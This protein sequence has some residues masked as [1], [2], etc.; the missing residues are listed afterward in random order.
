MP[1][2]LGLITL[3]TDFGDQ[4]SFVA[5][6][7]GVIL[8]INPQISFVDLSHH[9]PPHSV[10]VAAYLLK[11]CY[12]YFPEG[13]IHVAVVD[14]GVGSG[15]RP[16][17]VKT[18]GYYFLGPDNGLFSH[19]LEDEDEVE[20][21]EIEN[22]QYRLESVGHTFD[23]RDLFA[24]SAAWLAKGALP[25]SFGRIIHDP[26]RLSI[27]EPSRQGNRLVGRIEHVDRFGNL[28]SNLTL[29]HIL[30]FQ[31]SAGQ[32]DA[33][34]HIKGHILVGLVTSY[35]EGLRDRPAALINSNGRVEVFV[36]SKSAAQQLCAGV[37]V[38]IHLC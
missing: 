5:S 38:E 30:E 4:D 35:S 27:V 21:R 34:L 3:L 10:E 9:V 12:R 23:G 32:Q 28:I 24:P 20:I 19:I 11:S 22:Q 15:R 25:S 26:V 7:K 17:L 16:L 14:P 37:G 33:T 8:T 18:D 13:A 6:M 2:P 36:N 1:H 29:Q 31:S